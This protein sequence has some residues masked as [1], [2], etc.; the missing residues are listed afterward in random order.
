MLTFAVLSGPWPRLGVVAVAL[1]VAGAMLLRRN[2]LRAWAMLG[3][4]ALAPVLLL[5]DVWHTSHLSIIHRHHL[6]AAV[7]AILILLAVAAAAWAIH[8]WPMAIGPLTMLTLPFRIPISTGSS[9]SANL[10]VPLY[11]VVAAAV[12]AWSVPTLLSYRTSVDPARRSPDRNRSLLF[13]SLLAAYVVVYSLQALYSANFPQALQNEVFFYVP[14]ALLYT[15]LRSLRWDRDQLRRCL[16]LTAALAVLFACFGFYEEWKQTLLWNPQLI[17]A[18]EQHRY[19]TVNSVFF[20][21]NIFGR[22][23]ALV[24]VLVTAVLL[25]DRRPRIQAGACGVLAILWAGMIFTLSRSSLAALLLG[26]AA[27]AALRWRAKPILALG[28]VVVLVGIVAI[29]LSPTVQHQLGLNQGLN[30]ASSGRANLISGGIKLFEQRPLEGYGS[31]S[32]STEYTRHFPVSAR[33]VSDS[34]NIP[35]TIAAEQGVIGLIF[36]AAFVVAALLMLFRGA[37]GQ[38]ARVAVAAAFL[39]LLLHT[40]LYADFLED[41]VTWTL[42]GIG[43]A[44]ALNP[45]EMSAD[46]TT[47]VRKEPARQ[48]HRA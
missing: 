47:P 23:L 13:E 15:V 6:L 22:Y 42:L 24:M 1:L 8:R 19:F 32:F 17:A 27:L 35:V 40:M 48:L 36:Y 21:P 25:Y 34:H 31:G 5:D 30:N 38:P 37:R 43:A 18:D 44:L 4:L 12:L 26:L 11:F 46:A 10:L 29:A 7:A 33:S 39:A 14:F 9:T 45:P 20:D 28:G 2:D 16:T 3:A 41:P